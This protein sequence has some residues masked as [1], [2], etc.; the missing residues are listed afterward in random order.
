M[1]F[2]SLVT[3]KG[4]TGWGVAEAIFIFFF[5]VSFLSDDREITFRLGKCKG[6]RLFEGFIKKIAHF[7]F[8]SIQFFLSETDN[9]LVSANKN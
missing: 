2:L 6:P 7:F 5:S 9:F 8:I 3:P 1:I 4:F